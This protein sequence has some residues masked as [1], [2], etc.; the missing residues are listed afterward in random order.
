MKN[1]DRILP[2]TGRKGRSDVEIRVIF[3]VSW[4]IL[5]QA[6][7]DRAMPHLANSDRE[8]KPLQVD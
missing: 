1:H 7:G 2:E 5:D 6:V 3:D 8:A 4:E